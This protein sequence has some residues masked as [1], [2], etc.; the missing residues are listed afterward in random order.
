MKSLEQELNLKHSKFK[1]NVLCI[2]FP[3]RNNE[4]LFIV[5]DEQILMFCF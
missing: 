2:P 4:I 5:Y 1:E 3:I